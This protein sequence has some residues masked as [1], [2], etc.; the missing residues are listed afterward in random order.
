[1]TDDALSNVK[2]L[3]EALRNMGGRGPIGTWLAEIHAEKHRRNLARRDRVLLYADLRAALEA[4]PLN[5]ARADQWNGYVPPLFEQDA[6]AETLRDR[7]GHANGKRRH[8]R[9]SGT[10]EA[11]ERA[12]LVAICRLA[13]EREVEAGRTPEPEPDLLDLFPFPQPGLPRGKDYPTDWRPVQPALDS[14]FGRQAAP[15]ERADYQHEPRTRAGQD[16]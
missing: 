6:P 11:A 15:D 13:Y 4:P 10:N 7:A 1:M 3:S 14:D 9:A 2:P 8:T 16:D 12:V 5:Y